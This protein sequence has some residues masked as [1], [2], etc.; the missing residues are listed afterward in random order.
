MLC[1]RYG[2]FSIKRLP[3]DYLNLGA[4]LGKVGGAFGGGIPQHRAEAPI[5]LRLDVE[6]LMSKVRM[7]LLTWE[8]DVRYV[9]NLSPA[10]QKGVRDLVAVNRAA[11]TLSLHYYRFL[12][13]CVPAAALD[14]VDGVVELIGL[15][16]RCADLLGESL[17]WEWRQMPCG[18]CGAT[19]LGQWIGADNVECVKCGWFCSLSEY[20]T[21]VMTLVPP[22]RRSDV[23]GYYGYSNTA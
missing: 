6:A 19:S 23:N 3:I 15:H 10:P 9:A 20:R 12:S 4:R 16:R 7:T 14:G 13:L 5:P 21:Y 1:E 11:T 18:M 22:T 17:H 2:L 8:R